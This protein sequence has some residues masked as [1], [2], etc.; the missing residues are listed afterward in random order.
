MMTNGATEYA[1]FTNGL[2]SLTPSCTY[3]AT[4]VHVYESVAFTCKGFDS[5]QFI[6]SYWDGKPAGNGY[7]D[8]QGRCTGYLYV[9]PTVGGSHHVVVKSDSHATSTKTFTVLPAVQLQFQ[10]G[11]R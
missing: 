10:Q 1:N 5:Y 6:S 11:T 8:A 2:V 4:S 9:N 3:S 7:C